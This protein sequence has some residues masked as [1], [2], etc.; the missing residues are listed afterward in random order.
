VNNVRK[1]KLAQLLVK[2]AGHRGAVQGDLQGAGAGGG[3]EEPGK[4]RSKPESRK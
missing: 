1:L 3:A 2:D 4:H